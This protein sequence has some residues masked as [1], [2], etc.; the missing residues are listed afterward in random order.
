MAYFLVDEKKEF[1]PDYRCDIN[2]ME[3][4]NQLGLGQWDTIVLEGL[5]IDIYLEGTGINN[6]YKLLRSNGCITFLLD[7]FLLSEY[8]F[9]MCKRELFE[10]GIMLPGLERE[11]LVLTSFKLLEDSYR[12]CTE[13]SSTA[14]ASIMKN[15]FKFDVKDSYD[16][17]VTPAAGIFGSRCY[18]KY[19]GMEDFLSNFIVFIRKLPEE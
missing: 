4:L 17:W 7:S 2:D 19:L 8:Y 15:A 12:N 1:K 9:P 18:P 13:L 14:N 16:I 6:V 11:K 10:S 3:S 5:P